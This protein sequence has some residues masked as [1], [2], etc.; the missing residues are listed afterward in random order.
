MHVYMHIVFFL[1]V[2]FNASASDSDCGENCR[3]CDGKGIEGC[4]GCQA[5]FYLTA[6]KTCSGKQGLILTTLQ[7][8]S[9]MG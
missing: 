5:G 1:Y 9:P 7:M 8:S 2:Y 6:D 4:I 3:D